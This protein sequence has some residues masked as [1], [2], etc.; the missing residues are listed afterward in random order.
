MAL[1]SPRK[2]GKI[3]LQVLIHRTREI[4]QLCSG[5]TYNQLRVKLR[6]H[7]IAKVKMRQN[8]GVFAFQGYK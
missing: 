6:H 1:T 7:S 8:S 2:R 3:E 5:P 4:S